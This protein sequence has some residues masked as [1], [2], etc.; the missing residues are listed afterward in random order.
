M[1]WEEGERRAIKGGLCEGGSMEAIRRSILG[2]FP[3]SGS[4]R[5][6]CTNVWLQL[7]FLPGSGLLENLQTF[8]YFFCARPK[9]RRR[10]TQTRIRSGR[11]MLW[12]NFGA[13]LR[14]DGKF[15]RRRHL[16]YNLI[17]IS[18][19]IACCSCC[20]NSPP[21]VACQ[22]TSFSMPQHSS[23][24]SNSPATE[25]AATSTAHNKGR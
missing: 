16:A 21:V 5:C 14:R 24:I 12:S 7:K 4:L 18:T 8:C 2:F 13:C 11:W 3:E 25:A 23:D 22:K 20:C 19:H 6:G 10:K 15:A 17:P 9:V 1:G